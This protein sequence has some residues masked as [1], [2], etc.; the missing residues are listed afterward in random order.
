MKKNSTYFNSDTCLLCILLTRIKIIFFGH[1][2]YTNG[3]TTTK[4]GPNT[5]FYRFFGNLTKKIVFPLYC[6]IYRPV[7][8]LQILQFWISRTTSTFDLKFSPVIGID[9]IRLCAK[10]QFDYLSGW[11]FTDQSVNSF[12]LVARV[13]LL[14]I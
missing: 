1:F 12:C 2:K 9:D 5:C 6:V 3:L 11:Y 7:C 8:K 4:S 13:P 10:F 14:M